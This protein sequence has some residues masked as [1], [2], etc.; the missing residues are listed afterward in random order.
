MKV[1]LVTKIRS[2]SG[3]VVL[4]RLSLVAGVGLLAGRSLAT[5]PS[6]LKDSTESTEVQK[7]LDKYR[8]YRP[9]AKDLVLYQLDWLP[10]LKAAKEEA[11]KG[12]RP[13]LLM[14]VSNTN[15]NLLTGHC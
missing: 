10:T 6:E 1:K 8:A 11:A 9:E 2:Q 13:I 7:I 12:K 14:V 5:E 15:G 4:L 3:I